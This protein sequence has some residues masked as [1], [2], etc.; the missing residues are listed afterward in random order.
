MISKV[1]T[2]KHIGQLVKLFQKI[3][4][5][6][7]NS[8][9]PMVTFKHTL[10]A[11]L[12]LSALVAT[13]SA[14]P[15]V[16][17]GSFEDPDTN[18]APYLALYHAGDS[19]PG[20]WHVDYATY[21]ADIIN[22]AYTPGGVTWP[23]AVDGNAFLYLADSVTVSKISQIVQLEGGHNYEL[24]FWLSD[25][26]FPLYGAEVT[27]DLTAVLG[28]GSLLG[29]AQT[30]SHSSNPNWV[31][32]SVAFTAGSTG[33]YSLSFLSTNQRAANLDDIRITD[34]SAPSVPEATP[35]LGLLASAI[36]LA[37]GLRRRFA[38]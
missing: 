16:A 35:T 21:S 8:Q 27:T 28:G 4:I 36:A 15:I 19:M 18:N 1:A 10:L 6:I 9:L 33:D 38:R 5:A 23:D 25:F 29:G 32:Y 3:G 12:T 22:N 7:A 37:G 34:L 26:Q 20:G 17:N 13:S 14:T 31:Q 2:Q 24:S 30:F 11:G